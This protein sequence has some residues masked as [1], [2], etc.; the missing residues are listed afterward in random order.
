MRRVMLVSHNDT[1]KQMVEWLTVRGRDFSAM[2][3]F[4]TQSTGA[5]VVMKARMPVKFLPGPPEADE[6]ASTSKLS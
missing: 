3:F 1:M 4:V 5:E 6:Q 2:D